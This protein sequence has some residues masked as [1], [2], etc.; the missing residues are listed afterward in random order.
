MLISGSVTSK[1][2]SQT[3]SISGSLPQSQSTLWPWRDEFKSHTSKI[4]L[5]LSDS[6]KKSFEKA[7]DDE[8]QSYQAWKKIRS[9]KLRGLNDN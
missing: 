8:F 5:A 7:L 2:D 4:S 9:V 1:V 6:I 3:H